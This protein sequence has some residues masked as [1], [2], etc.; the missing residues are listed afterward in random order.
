MFI[1][2]SY[3]TIN[4]VSDVTSAPDFIKMVLDQNY[5]LFGD[6]MSEKLIDQFQSEEASSRVHL[7]H[8]DFELYQYDQSKDLSKSS[9]GISI[10]NKFSQI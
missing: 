2:D 4:N 5:T 1:K 6:S 8:N 9:G 10:S 3:L 7:S